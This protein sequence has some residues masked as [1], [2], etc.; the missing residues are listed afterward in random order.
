MQIVYQRPKH[1]AN[2]KYKTFCIKRILFRDV[3]ETH[4]QLQLCLNLSKRAVCY[5]IELSCILFGVSIM[6]LCYIRGNRNNCSLNLILQSICFLW[7]KAF[8]KIIYC[9]A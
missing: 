7:R 1:F 9:F 5:I 8:G 2:F 3:S 6:P 4:S